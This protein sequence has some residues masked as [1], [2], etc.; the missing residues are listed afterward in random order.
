ML[1]ILHLNSYYNELDNIE[2]GHQEWINSLFN[3]DDEHIKTI[4]DM[5]VGMYHMVNKNKIYY[6]DFNKYKTLDNYIEKNI[7]FLHIHGMSPEEPHMLLSPYCSQGIKAF[8]NLFEIS[9]RVVCGT[10]YS[11]KVVTLSW[12]DLNDKEFLVFLFR[13]LLPDYEYNH[14]KVQ[15]NIKLTPLDNYTSKDP[16]KRGTH[17]L[18]IFG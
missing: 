7:H 6:F 17:L 16:I 1:P 9:L 13:N 10:K 3:I 15:V 4:N 2:A 12:S 11:F 14:G 8:L 18:N 5:N